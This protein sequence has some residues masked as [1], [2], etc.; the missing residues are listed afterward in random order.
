MEFKSGCKLLGMRTE[1]LAGLMVADEVY[2]SWSTIMVVTSVTDGQHMR[3][4]IHYSGGAA[5]LRTRTLPEGKVEQVASE[6]A[7][8]LGGEFDVILEEDHIHI[9][10]QPK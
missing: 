5:D 3:A 2:R 6:I 1:L 9:E 7:E 10:F 4:S 8:A